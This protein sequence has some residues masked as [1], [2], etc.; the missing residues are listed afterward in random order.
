MPKRLD[1]S[2]SASAGMPSAAAAA[3]ASSIR[4]I[5][6]TIEYSVCRG[7]WTIVG[8]MVRI[9]RP[10]DTSTS[11]E[12]PRRQD[13]KVQRTTRKGKQKEFQI[14]DLH[15]FQSGHPTFSTLTIFLAFPWRLGGENMHLIGIMRVSSKQHRTSCE[16]S[17]SPVISSFRWQDWAT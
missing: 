5:P 13:A 8:C 16:S 17:T 4:A 6:S 2:V 10:K 9:L 1:R 14:F 7:R 11:N 15:S 3:T 12:N